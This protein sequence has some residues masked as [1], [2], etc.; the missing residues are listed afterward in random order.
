MKKVA[1]SAHGS[2]NHMS[3][4]LETITVFCYTV[5]STLRTIEVFHAPSRNR[6]QG[7]MKC[8]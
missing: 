2:N 6:F 1:G 4:F 7:Q 5:E 8:A 3:I